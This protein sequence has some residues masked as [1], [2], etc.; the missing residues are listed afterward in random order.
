MDSQT[1]K[2]SVEL[3]SLPEELEALSTHFTDLLD[4]WMRPMAARINRGIGGREVALCITKVQ[5]ARM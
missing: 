1:D 3:P 4:Q 2:L 5:E